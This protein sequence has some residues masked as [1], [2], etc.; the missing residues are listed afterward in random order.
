[1]SIII[2]E[3]R[4]RTNLSQNGFAKK[5]GIPVS[6]LRKW[7]QGDTTPAPYIV[8]MLAKQIKGDNENLQKIECKDGSIFYY[9]PISSVLSDVY[10]NNIIIKEQLDGVKSQNLP[11]YVK[12]LI[13]SFYEIQNKFNQDI[14]FDKK[15]DIKIKF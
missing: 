13:E 15:E 1:M 9:D 4:D 2:K 12:D 5:Y 11:L 8:S 6:T 14:I 10:G 3:L 7:E